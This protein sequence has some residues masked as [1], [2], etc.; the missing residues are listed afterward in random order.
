MDIIMGDMFTF[1]SQNPGLIASIAFIITMIAFY[2]TRRLRRRQHR[3]TPSS[4]FRNSSSSSKLDKANDQT[5][6]SAMS[7]IQTMMNRPVRTVVVLGAGGHCRE[8]LTLLSKVDLNTKYC[9]ILFLL[10]RDDVMSLNKL[11]SSGLINGPAISIQFISRSRQVGQS[12]ITSIFTTLWSFFE[13]I[14]ILRR[15]GCELLICNGPGTCI[16]PL[17]AV[18]M[19][20]SKASVVFIESFCRTQTLSLSGKIAYYLADHILVQWPELARKNSR[21]KYIGL[22]V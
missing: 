12:Y 18:K 3:S 19:L 6:R 2:V 10:S 9:P 13:S 15:F 1:M 11:K 22:M 21:C 4:S 16:P 14:H 20:F 8:M 5:C 17:I 7:D